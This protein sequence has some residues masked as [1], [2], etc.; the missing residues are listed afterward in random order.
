MTKHQEHHV[1]Q[2]IPFCPQTNS[3]EVVSIHTDASLSST[4]EPASSSS[5]EQYFTAT[6]FSHS[7]PNANEDLAGCGPVGNADNGVC[8]IDDAPSSKRTQDDVES[9]D[10]SALPEDG[11]RALA[12]SA[13]HPDTEYHANLFAASEDSRDLF[14]EYYKKT[15]GEI[16]DETEDLSD[17][18]W[19]WNQK[20][21]DW[22]HENPDTHSIVWF[23][24]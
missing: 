4:S 9:Y 2:S 15:Y 16:V 23:L 7:V 22:F 5:R 3:G 10:L 11:E 12:V 19:R 18:Y 14:E 13:T 20:R 24:G 6:S 21:H 8:L 1:E 17:A